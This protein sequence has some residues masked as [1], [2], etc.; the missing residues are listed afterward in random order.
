[1][2]TEPR[3]RRRAQEPKHVSMGGEGRARDANRNDGS[4]GMSGG[5]T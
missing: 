1:V 2:Q 5:L 4:D 3:L